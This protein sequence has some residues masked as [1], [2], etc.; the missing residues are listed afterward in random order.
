M[1]SHDYPA[2]ITAGPRRVPIPKVD[3]ELDLVVEDAGTG[4]CGAVVAVSKDVVTLEDRH[5]RRRVFPL[6]AGGFLLE[7]RA[8][9][10]SRPSVPLLAAPSTTASGSVAVRNA[11][12]RTARASR[13]YVEGVHDAALVERI[14]GDDL[15]VEGIVVEP[16]HGIDD[17]PVIVTDFG[18]AEHRRL[19][20]L[21]DHLV[22]GSKESRIVASVTS[23]HVLVTGH[24]YVDIWAAVRPERL[25]IAA[26]PDVPKGQPW[27][28][29]IC[30]AL[31]VTDERDMWR[32]VLSSVST[33]ADV[34]TPLVTAVERLIDFVFTAAG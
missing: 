24:P 1:R 12:A 13:I 32:R 31:G 21:V 18:P 34:Q 10:L 25:G 6:R 22:P 29:G 20:V 8:V 17:L 14:W 3:A 26:W 15:R 23:P 33:Y 19:G 27:K 4:F 9:T 2:D 7:G 28:A 11:A 30:A 16:L 5:Q